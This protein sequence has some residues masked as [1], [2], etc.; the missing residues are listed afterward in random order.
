MPKMDVYANAKISIPW[1]SE[2]VHRVLRQYINFEYLA[3]LMSRQ[4]WLSLIKQTLTSSWSFLSSG[5][6]FVFGLLSWLIVFLYVIFIMIDYE[7]LMLSFRQLVPHEHRRRV[8]RIF[9]DIKNAMMPA[10]EEFLKSQPGDLW[11]TYQ[12]ICDLSNS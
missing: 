9:N 6:A 5:L 8:F 2:N 12:A 1:L 3:S 11:T 10:I 4:E 7:R